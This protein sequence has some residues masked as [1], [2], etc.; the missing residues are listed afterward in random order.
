MQLKITNPDLIV[1]GSYY[2][3]NVGDL[4]IGET[5]A[6]I[7]SSRYNKKCDT[8]GFFNPLFRGF[9]F[10]NYII[11]GGGVLHDFKTGHLTKRLELLGS[12]QNS[13]VLGVGVPGLITDEGKKIIK[14][15]MQSDLVTV[16]DKYSYDVLS[17]HLNE[18][19]IHITACPTFLLAPTKRVSSFDDE[20]VK[21]GVSLRDW[22]NPVLRWNRETA[23]VASAYF[24]E[25]CNHKISKNKYIEFVKKNL[26]T[27]KN[28]YDLYF[29]PFHPDD[30]VFCKKYFSDYFIE[31]YKV[32]NPS[33]TLNIINSMDV[34]ICMRYH[35]IIFS[36]LCNKP[37]YV[38]SYRKKTDEIM[39]QTGLNG[40]SIYSIRGNEVIN[41]DNNIRD[42]AKAT[43]NMRHKAMRNFLLLDK[44]LT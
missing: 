28:K 35:S 21:C 17:K 44:Y 41:F 3:R 39:R 38:I 40:I 24:P 14:D 20:K 9:N 22:F 26:Y 37:I 8:L 6:N 27:L 10:N 2:T 13:F 5:I 34:M 4:A 30:V 25:N 7:I 36:M 1:H 31:I 32:K 42:V 12:A 16:R 29:I 43:E 18:K 15:L 11:G 33:N 23:P 19:K